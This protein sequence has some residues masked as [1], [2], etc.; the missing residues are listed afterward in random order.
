MMR[1][2]FCSSALAI[3]IAVVPASVA[4]QEGGISREVVDHFV[5]G[6]TVQSDG[7]DVE[8]RCAPASED[9]YMRTGRTTVC[10]E[11]T[12]VLVGDT[13]GGAIRSTNRAPAQ[14]RVAPTPAPAP[15]PG[16]A[17]QPRPQRVSIP[18]ECAPAD[19][20]SLNMCLTFGLG[21]SELTSRAKDQI[22]VFADSIRENQVSEPFTIAGHTD[23]TGAADRNCALSQQRAN[24]VV[25]YMVELGVSATQLHP[26][27]YGQHRLQENIGDTDPRNRRVEIRRGEQA[28]AANSDCGT[29]FASN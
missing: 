4:A 22:R 21:S 6:G 16:P 2:I 28:A 29:N 23:V 18:V 10:E 19:N 7:E 20:A 5:T 14:T 13:G 27:G 1:S 17:P 8:A 3:V 9:E 25:S 11:R 12:F 24:S 26:V 15:R